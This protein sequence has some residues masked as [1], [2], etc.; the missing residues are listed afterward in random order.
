ML[1][2]HHTNWFYQGTQGCGGLGK[3]E[4][5]SDIFGHVGGPLQVRSASGSE[6]CFTPE[7]ANRLH[8]E[9]PGCSKRAKHHCA[10]R[11]LVG[12]SLGYLK[13]FMPVAMEL[14]RFSYRDREFG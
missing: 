12:T 5:T 1:C 3:D 9:A 14:Y 13:I 4:W 11:R 10:S 6:C 8:R 2:I 7:S